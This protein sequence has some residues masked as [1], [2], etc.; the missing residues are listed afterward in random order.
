LASLIGKVSTVILSKE[1]DRALRG[2]G[3][4]ESLYPTGSGLKPLRRKEK[5]QSAQNT[6]VRSQES[7][8]KETQKP[9]PQPRALAD[10]PAGSEA[11]RAGN[12]ETRTGLSSF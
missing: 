10:L 12:A 1:L 2:N 8:E 6:G 7:G 3:R 5:G 9:E 11:G 4:V